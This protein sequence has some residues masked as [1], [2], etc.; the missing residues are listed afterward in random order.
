MKKLLFLIIYN[1]VKIYTYV[2]YTYYD[3]RYLILRKYLYIIL[4]N[5]LKYIESPSY[6]E[7]VSTYYYTV[8]T[9]FFF[10]QFFFI[11]SFCFSF[12][13]TL[14]FILLKKNLMNC[15]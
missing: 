3:M 5:L 14:C 8:K 12:D 13:K 1:K 7:K 11:F 15:L 2:D 9:I 4:I 6:I 10:L